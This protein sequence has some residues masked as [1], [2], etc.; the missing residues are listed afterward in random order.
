MTDKKYTIKSMHD[1]STSLVVIGDNLNIHSYDNVTTILRDDAI[2][3]IV[4]KHGF[5]IV[6]EKL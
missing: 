2:V 1:M 4:P 3:A 6:T 5:I